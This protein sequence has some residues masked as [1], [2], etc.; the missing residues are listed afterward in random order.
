MHFQSTTVIG[1]SAPHSNAGVWK[2][3]AGD[4]IQAHGGGLLCVDDVWYWY[5]EN[6]SGASSVATT[7]GGQL[8]E[9]VDVVGVSGYRSPDLLNWEP[10][11]VVLKSQPGGVNHD[12]HPSG[13]LE[14]PKVIFHRAS[15]TFV[16]WLHIDRP[17]YQ[18][19]AAGVAISD[20]PEGPFRYLGSVRP[21]GRDSRDQTVFSDDD[22]TAYHLTSTDKNAT[23]LV[24]RLTSNFRCLSE[25]SRVLFPNRHM[26][27][28]AITK[29][30]GRYWYLASGC[31]G[32][33]P[34]EA[35]SAV[36]DSI[37]GPW[38]E[39]GNPCRGGK[40]AELTWGTQSTFLQTLPDGRI[41]A[42]FDR[43]KP[44]ALSESQYVW[45]VSEPNPDGLVLNWDQTWR[46][47]SIPDSAL[48]SRKSGHLLPG[49]LA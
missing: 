20:R 38:E 2:D 26:E 23:V 40:N 16:M 18:L 4:A 22:G 37:F 28:H 43:W 17:N 19:A 3:T 11:G 32:W 14:R 41:L 29:A 44:E 5:G 21:Q 8:V 10:M 31:T 35:R 49:R 30:D 36:A 33:L 6:K 45:I 39:T 1:D 48:A 42:M 47:L 27:A 13:V 12:L 25:E 15:G 9:R 46:G 34:N 24:T 7:A